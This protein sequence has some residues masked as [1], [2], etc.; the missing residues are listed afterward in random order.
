MKLALVK[1]NDEQAREKVAFALESTFEVEVDQCSS[2]KD[3]L[4]KRRRTQEPCHALIL[5][6]DTVS[7]KEIK[8]I[9]ASLASFPI[10]YCT[11]EKMKDTGLTLD[12]FFLIASGQD[13]LQNVI[14]QL[15]D[16]MKKGILPEVPVP[17]E[18]YCKIKTNI[19]LSVYPLRGD[20]HIKL[21]NQHYV[22]VFHEGDRFDVVDLEK[23]T[24][25]KGIEFLYIKRKD[26]PEFIQKYNAELQRKPVPAS[27]NVSLKDAV[28]A[29]G[30]TQEMIVQ[31]GFSKDVQML[32]RSY[33]QNAV[34]FMN[35]SRRL[36]DFVE[37]MEN[38]SGQYLADHSA[39][40]GYLAC[41]IAANH[42]WGSEATFQKLSLAA[43]LH[44]IVLNNNDLGRCRTVDEA[45]K[46]G[47]SEK[48]VKDY[49]NHPNASAQLARQLTEVPPDVDVII[50]QHH[51]RPDGE[52][53]PRRLS[54][55]HIS[56]LSALFIIA[57][58]LADYT[59]AKG[60]DASVAEFLNQT[61]D[62]YSPSRF[63][64][65]LN[66]LQESMRKSA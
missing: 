63:R 28:E 58:D 46:A 24:V 32:A 2:L 21:S 48:E 49:E 4:N 65:V 25:Q 37:R 3:F 38:T 44:D 14:R 41:A 19:L 1:R 8:D 18:G 57:H 45:I 60:K 43:L 29:F 5:D 42:E 23:Y 51:E 55:S 30:V 31:F 7:L 20:V 56:P 50:L 59:L 6:S 52:G 33:A 13:L 66:A 64:S 12:H 16:L 11:N 10:I 34:K 15:K 47:F 39:L 27:V 36:K 9:E 22:K 53:F 35:K 62:Y 17:R 40:T 26:A 54:H 61:K